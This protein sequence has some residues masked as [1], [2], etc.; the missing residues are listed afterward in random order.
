M[1]LVAILDSTTVTDQKC[2]TVGE[3]YCVSANTLHLN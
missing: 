2:S 1:D 3:I